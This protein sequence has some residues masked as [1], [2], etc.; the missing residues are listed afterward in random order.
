MK[1]ALWVCLVVG[2]VLS[3][4]S[5]GGKGEPGPQGPKGDQGPQGLK[6]DQ[7]LQG[8][9]GDQGLQGPKGDQG[10]QGPKGA[11]GTDG[12]AGPPG[13]PG[14]WSAFAGG[15]A[16]AIT[17]TVTIN[18]K[19][20]CG[21]VAP[22]PHMEVFADHVRIGGVD[23]TNSTYADTT[24]TLPSPRFI[25]ELTV[26][27]TNDSAAGGCDHNLYVDHITLSTGATISSSDTAHVVYDRMTTSDLAT[28][29]D[30][31]DVMSVSAGIRM[32]WSGGLRFFVGASGSLAGLGGAASPIFSTK[33]NSTRFSNSSPQKWEATGESIT[34]S[35]P[36]EQPARY[37]IAMRQIFTNQASGTAYCVVTL[38]ASTAPAGT[39]SVSGLGK[40]YG[41]PAINYWQT[42]FGEGFFQVPAGQ[43]IQLNVNMVTDSGSCLLAN[44]SSDG[45]V[46]TSV[47][48]W[49]L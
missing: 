39:F 11:N 36:P 38:T 29:F 48:A 2:C 42:V 8:P 27:F 41:S 40:L 15:A 13:P 25:G 16:Q 32:S 44:A 34:L 37:R 7:G 24:L 19:S 49:P 3:A 14:N 35:A 21:S 9:Q 47:I 5:S 12:A 18:A 17:T 33:A 28:A 6:G 4:C 23:V 1:N 22:A 20:D 43:T 31:V 26:V 10:P 46:Y 45:D 30:G